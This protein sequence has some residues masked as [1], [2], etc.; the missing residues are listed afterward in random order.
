M[1]ESSNLSNASQVRVGD[2]EVAIDVDGKEY[3]LRPSY[4][5][6]KTISSRY[7]GIM[8]ALQRV[9]NVDVDAIIDVICIG[10]G[11]TEHKKPSDDFKDKIWRAGFT[12]D[13]SRLLERCAHYLRTLS[14]G[15]RTPRDNAGAS[16][17]SQGN[18]P[19]G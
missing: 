16:G 12:D 1:T 6:A 7:G 8:G 11:F 19:S 3:I 5:A 2:G 14:S 9:G 10:I 17:D 13:T 4:Y 15:G 18:P